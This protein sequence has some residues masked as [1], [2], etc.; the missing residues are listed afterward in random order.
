AC[1][2]DHAALPAHPLA[3]IQRRSSMAP[4]VRVDADRHGGCRLGPE[5]FLNHTILL[6]MVPRRTAR[7]RAMQTSLESLLERASGGPQALL[8]PARRRQGAPRAIRQTPSAVRLQTV[9]AYPQVNKS[10]ARPSPRRGRPDAHES[11]R[12]RG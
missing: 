1:E 8:E 7:L 2:G 4:L 6:A 11:D 3:P 5:T 9:P 12:V 10:G